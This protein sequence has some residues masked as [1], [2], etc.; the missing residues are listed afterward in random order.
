M[1]NIKAA[2]MLNRPVSTSHEVLHL[3]AEAAEKSDKAASKSRASGKFPLEGGSTV[4]T[5]RE[6]SSKELLSSGTLGPK[7]ELQR[8]DPEI[9]SRTEELET[10]ADL[11]MALKAWSNMRFVRAGWFTASEG[12]SYIE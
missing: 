7:A 1:L 6:P 2:K 3:L 4:P 10:S 9:N 11:R 12:I 5:Y 8:S